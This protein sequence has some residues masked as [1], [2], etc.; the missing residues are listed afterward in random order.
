MKGIIIYKGKYGAT[1][2]YAKWLAEELGQAAISSDYI[3]GI[4]LKQF[5]FI[6]IG[7]SVYIG[8]LSIKKWLE[9]NLPYLVNKPLY[10]F[11]V[12]GSPVDQK[13]KRME[14]NRS[15]V[16]PPLINRCE[17]FYLPG[18]LSIENLSWKDRFMLKM[19][20]RL[21][22]KPADKKAMLTN[23]D[24]VKKNNLKELINVIRQKHLNISKKQIAVDL[25]ILLQYDNNHVHS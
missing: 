1:E 10:L 14:Y 12:A 7:S 5:D 23:Y 24:L 22:K 8:K 4:N 3:S 18:R 13:E 16:P 21:A 25:D 15:S 17:Y 2:Q 19:G 11:Q 9:A 20:A 6:V